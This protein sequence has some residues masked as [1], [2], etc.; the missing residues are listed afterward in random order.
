MNNA[1]EILQV[2]LYFGQVCYHGPQTYLTPSTLARIIRNYS[3]DSFIVLSGTICAIATDGNLVRFNLRT[4]DGVFSIR[5]NL[6]QAQIIGEPL[7]R[8]AEICVIGR[9]KAYY[10]RQRR[11]NLVY[12]EALYCCLASDHIEGTQVNLEN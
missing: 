12:V 8:S 5:V 9:P 2:L 3:M 4:I 11:I 6:E 10:H 7:Y 1:L